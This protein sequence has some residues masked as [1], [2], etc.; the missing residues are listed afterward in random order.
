MNLVAVQTIAV[1][2]RRFRR[3]G[4]TLIELI[5]TLTI[6][7][8]LAMMLTPMLMLEVDRATRRDEEDRLKRMATA[9]EQAVSRNRSIPSSTNWATVVANQI[10]W[11]DGE[12]QA[13]ARG[14]A[15]VY[16]IDP[17]LR[18]GTTSS[19]VL[20]YSQT[21]QG[22]LPPTSARVVFVSSLGEPLPD[23]LTSGVASSTN[24]FNNI[25]AASTEEM[26]S[27]WTWTGRAADLRIQRVLL[28]P[29]LVP[30]VLN[31]FDAAMGRFGLDAGATNLMTTN[32]F[33]TW[34]LK[35]TALRL[36]GNDG[37]LQSTEVI[38]DAVSYVYE[39][40][41]WRGRAFMSMGSKR[42]SGQDLQ[43]AL[44]LFLAS[45]WNANAKTA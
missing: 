34:Y 19:S 16:L 39:N 12:V 17:A 45:P 18:V 26:P 43:D 6:I 2:N 25:W 30:V 40:G 27:G 5:G 24:V 38:Q 33:S 41:I 13:N 20:P 1:R 42:L 7:S 9:Y 8:I 4:F 28:E 44:D 22:S 29:L 32:V 23:T 21:W 15:R 10:G 35:G 36:H 3:D 14:N 11:R 31:S 37:T